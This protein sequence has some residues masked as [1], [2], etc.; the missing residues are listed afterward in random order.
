MS[1]T[2][3]CEQPLLDAAKAGSMRAFGELLEKQRF[4]LLGHAR[5][6]LSPVLRVK[7]DEADL[8]Q[9]TF[10]VALQKFPAFSGHSEEE[11]AVWLLRILMRRAQDLRKRYFGTAKRDMGREIPLTWD[12]VEARF[13]RPR[14]GEE[15]EDKD[16]KHVEILQQTLSL[17]PQH[18]QQVV[19]LHLIQ[20]KTFK[21]IG[22]IMKRSEKAVK[23]V[24]LRALRR[25][26]QE[27]DLVRKS[28]T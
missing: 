28:V 27:T 6:L 20:E 26:S 5:R 13:S 7:V 24:W 8:V 18:Y 16:K 10:V 12:V 25:L 9:D 21:E 14:D 1:L 17:L 4:R 2:L 15:M 23:K 19:R 22:A 3:A 11:F